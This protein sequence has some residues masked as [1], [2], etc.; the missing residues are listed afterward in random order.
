VTG[1]P[2][3]AASLSSQPRIRVR[4]KIFLFLFGFG[5][6]AYVQQRSITV[7]SYQM[8]PQLGLTQMQ[9]GWL[10]TALLVGYTTLQFPGGVIGQRLGARLMFV[11]IGLIAFG[12]TLAT[13]LAPLLVGGTTLFVV[14]AAAQL[15]MGASQAPI[16]P[17]SAGVFETWFTAD[18]W[19]LVQGLQSMGLGLGAALTPPLI[20]WLM[21][22]FDWQRALAW[23]TL[24]AL[25][26]IL[27]W[28]WYGRDR[29]AEHP[30]ITAAELAEL[31]AHS[32]ARV[33]YKI[34]WRGVWQLISS[35]D[36]LALTVSY[37]CMN[38]VYYLLANWCFLYLVQE[39]HFTVLESGWL[40]S[41][42][43]LAAAIGAGLGGKLASTLGTRYGARHG[44]RILPLISLPAAGLLQFLAVDAANAYLA[45]AALALCFAC[46]ELNEGPYWA[47][48]MHVGRGDTMA[49]GGLLNTGGNAGGLIA[50]PIV[51]Y[52]SGHHSWTQAFLIGT[53]FAV[54][55]A[56][57]WLLVDPTRRAGS[58]E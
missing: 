50:T 57:L 20:A 5:F 22:A 12:A 11:I 38:Y 21:S 2:A 43:P 53:A 51:A 25:V 18:K 54:A 56:A 8:M 31:G 49:A 37:I 41:T 29:P 3:A 6:M 14:L 44:L 58:G 7:A 36:V 9:L 15:V 52:L 32:A 55:S 39:R 4:W 19:P 48:I 33:D 30:S 23:S 24:P 27:W 10:E 34:S 16:F 28:A 1:P 26:L 47:A 13:P 35:R 42:P 40:A 45:V 17:V 46:V